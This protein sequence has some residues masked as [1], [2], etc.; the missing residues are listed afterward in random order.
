MGNKIVILQRNAKD[1]EAVYQIETYIKPIKLI[2]HEK[3]GLVPS[4]PSVTTTTLDY[5]LFTGGH[6]A[7]NSGTSR[8]M[9]G[10]TPQ[11]A[12]SWIQAFPN[13]LKGKVNAIILDTCFTSSFVS[14]FS[15]LLPVGGAI[16]CAHGTCDGYRGILTNSEYTGKT[17]GVAL[18]DFI[19][20]L[21][22]FQQSYITLS[23]YV[24]EQ[25]GG[26]LYT[27]NQGNDRTSGLLAMAGETGNDTPEKLEQL[28]SFVTQKS[29]TIEGVGV[30][31]LQSKLKQQLTMSI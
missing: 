7:F 9:D 25:S 15:E 6:G 2:T 24:K 31:A 8:S 30:S 28:D 19:D 23:I 3:N 17:V 13:A 10:I 12:Q 22:I 20:N 29:I 1:D 11:R 26:R 16:V 4:L 18:S 14:M 21:L 27:N 5:I